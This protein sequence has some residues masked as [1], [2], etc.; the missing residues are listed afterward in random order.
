MYN[1]VSGVMH[2]EM[3]KVDRARRCRWAT[4]ADGISLFVRLGLGRWLFLG[5]A[6]GRVVLGLRRVGFALCA[7]A[8]RLLDLVLVLFEEGF[9]LFWSGR[10]ALA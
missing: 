1:G 3:T 4:H 2:G 7:T 5:V 6:R 9:L 8:A 10:G